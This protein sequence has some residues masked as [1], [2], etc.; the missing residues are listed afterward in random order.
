MRDAVRSPGTVVIHLW[1][2]SVKVSYVSKH[3]NVSSS[4]PAPLAMMR[5]RWFDCM[6]LLTHPLRTFHDPIATHLP[7]GAVLFV[8]LQSFRQSPWVDS[9]SPLIAPTYRCNQTI[10][11]Y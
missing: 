5:T 10:E 3:Q 7:K 9:A 8:G 6:A 11:E 4:P 1:D 2:A